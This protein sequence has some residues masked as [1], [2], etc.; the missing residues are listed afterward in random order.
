MRQDEFL[1]HRNESWIG[2]AILKK[3]M[4]PPFKP[5]MQREL[6]PEDFVFPENQKHATDRDPQNRYG[7]VIPVCNASHSF[8]M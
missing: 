7:N 5:T 3:S 2:R 4:D 1:Q 8:H 6:A